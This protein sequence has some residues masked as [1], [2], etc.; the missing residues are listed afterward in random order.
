MERANGVS[1]RVTIL[2]ISFFLFALL[3]L[4]KLF[5]IQVIKNK[6]YTAL[7]FNQ[8]WDAKTLPS[9]RGDI[10]SKDFFP[11]ATSKVT[12]LM[13][14]EPERIEDK[15]RYVEALFPI[16]EKTLDENELKEKD[17]YKDE[18]T[19]SLV[20]D[21]SWVSVWRN[22]TEDQKL[23]IEELR[24]L[25]VGFEEEPKRYYPEGVFASHI[26][27][28]VGGSETGEEKGYFGVEG[29]FDGDLGGRPG[30]ILEERGASG[31]PILFGGYKKVPPIEG[32]SL[33]LTIDR[34][35]QFL[36]EQKLKDGVEKYGAQ[37][38]SAIIVNPPS[39]DILVMANYPTF[40]PAHFDEEVKESTKDFKILKKN[41]SITDVYEPGS[42]AKPLTIASAIDLGL[43]TPDT[44]FDD[45][46]PKVYS[47]HI[48]DTWN[49]KHFG[50]QSTTQILE[51]SNNVL[52]SVV[53][54][55]VGSK[56]LYE[57]FSKFGLGELTGITLEGENTGILRDPKDSRDIDLATASFGQGI[58]ASVLQMAMAF[59]VF[60]N[61][62]FLMKPRIVSKII[63]GKREIEIPVTQKR[64]V[65]SEETTN[66]MVK[67]LVSAVDNGESKYFNIKGYTISGK[68]G[69]AQIPIN[70]EYDPSKTNAT[71]VG[72]LPN[73]PQ[74]K[75]FVMIVK[76]EKPTSSIYAAET[77]VPLWMDML[78]DLVIMLKIPPDR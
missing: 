26:L 20:S 43:I 46:G 49:K 71:F 60:D 61:N 21:L 68:T 12:Y 67:M 5:Y 1:L 30:R 66:K 69:T 45:D 17:K 39:G 27:G 76:L 77:A 13:F 33:V 70:G 41:I 34:A 2:E 63:D 40:D 29:Y 37:S 65:I 72:F 53:G 14:F 38:G 25:G 57:Y 11:V 35:L 3:I 48:I 18:L 50:K 23:Q 51:K 36:V 22:L 32:R 9:K 7:A 56:N 4:S 64:R 28:F 47:G 15:D 6:E 44:I 52:A 59:S 55:L 24:F 73:S 54:T 74:N 58:S 16:L 31:G 19:Q 78:R 10:F 42:V 75:K 62:G 8:H